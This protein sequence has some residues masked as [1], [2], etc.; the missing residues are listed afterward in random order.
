[1]NEMMVKP[2]S[3]KVAE[4]GVIGTLL[5]NNEFAMRNNYL[6]HKH[7]FYMEHVVIYQA[8]EKLIASGVVSF[9]TFSIFSTIEAD[10]ELK[11]TIEKTNVDVIEFIEDAKL[12]ARSEYK[13]FEKLVERVMTLSFKRTARAKLSSLLI[14][15]NT[16]DDYTLNEFNYKLQNDITNLA[17]DYVFGNDTPLLADVIDDVM[18]EIIA[19]RSTDGN[20]G[21]PSAYKNV[22]RYFT[23]RKGELV[24]IGG[25]AKAG[26][27][28]FVSNEVY[29]KLQN[30]EQVAIFD[31]ELTDKIWL[32][33]FLAEITGL[34]VNQ[35][36]SGRYNEEEDRR[37]QDAI[38]WIKSGTLVHIYDPEWTMDKIYTRAKQIKLTH[39]LDLLIYDYI[40]AD[41]VDLKGMQEHTYL[42]KLTSFLKNKVA[43]ELDLAVIAPAQM[44][45]NE[46][47]LADSRKIQRYASTI[48]YWMEKDFD[49]IANDGVEEGTH[50]IFV[51]YNRNGGKHKS[52]SK[53]KAVTYINFVMDG[54]RATIKMAK[55]P[56][57]NGD[58]TPFD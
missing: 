48:C 26:K 30:G 55:I 17:N 33:R 20:V 13:E 40:K 8:I 9:D 47:R 42:G 58:N 14:D 15:C 18:N 56:Y 41:D 4:I 5:V 51:D 6:K 52:D 2:L 10:T 38:A 32:P 43:G 39:G 35:I 3:D 11:A 36:E 54:D 19:Q 44:N 50:Y 49:Q 45:D 31:T 21:I 28:V 53:G 37:I 46:L 23:Y 12:V 25:R 27:S 22:N 1:M 34:T 57:H 7:F 29:H 24:V 16:D